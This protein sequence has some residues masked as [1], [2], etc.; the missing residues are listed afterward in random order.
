VAG[1][2]WLG[3]IIALVK[4]VI[5]LQFDKRKNTNLSLMNKNYEKTTAHKQN[6]LHG[7]TLYNIKREKYKAICAELAF[8]KVTLD[9]MVM[10]FYRICIFFFICNIQRVYDQRLELPL[11]ICS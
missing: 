9:R 3:F 8:T 6:I 7:D 1:L 5:D 10:N 2:N 4:G 11:F